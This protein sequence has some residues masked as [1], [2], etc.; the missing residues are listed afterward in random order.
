[1]SLWPFRFVHAADFRLEQPPW[2]VAE[3]PDHLREQFLEAAYWAAERV[4]EIVLSEQAE[5]LV[6]S[7][8]VLQPEQTGPRGPLFLSEQFERLGERG[9]EVYWAGGRLDP[10]NAWPSS[11]RLPENVHVFPTGHPQQFVRLREGVPVVRLIGTSRARGLE[12]HPGDFLPDP[13]GLFSIAV[14]H[15]A[16]GAAALQS[17]PIDYWALG[18]IMSRSTL[19]STPRV[20]HYPGSPQ[21]RRPEHAGPHGCTLVHVD[22]E[23]RVRMTFVPSDLMRWQSERIAVDETTTRQNLEARL[24][25]RLQAVREAN[26]AVDLL[27]SWS[28]GGGGPL[29]SQLRRGKLGQELLAALRRDHGMGS[30]AAWSVSLAAEPEEVLPAAWYEQETI[31]GDFL[32][33][34]RH[35][36]AHPDLPLPLEAYLPEQ[37]RSG[38]VATAAQVADPAERERVL[39]EAAVLGIDLLSGEEPRS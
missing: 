7:G 15:G 19:S 23:R 22:Q 33:Q 28:V 38:A 11:V 24:N 4:F 37:H 29:L 10:P 26:P 17:H 25:G 18:G 35:Y 20:A 16:A 9:I 32:R 6:L 8:N 3:V 27:I 34:L 39:R 36:Q 13:A 2:G 14:A 30:P 12:I 5:F 1:M 31:C 21:G